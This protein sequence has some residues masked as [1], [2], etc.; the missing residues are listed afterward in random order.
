MIHT[1]LEKEIPVHLAKVK[2]VLYTDF[3][4]RTDEIIAAACTDG[5]LSRR[6]ED[7][8]VRAQTF[9]D[10]IE[11]Y[12]IA[13]LDEAVQ[14]ITEIFREYSI[15][16]RLYDVHKCLH[17]FQRITLL[18]NLKGKEYYC[19]VQFDSSNDDPLDS[20]YRVG[21]LDGCGE[22]IDGDILTNQIRF[23]DEGEL[24]FWFTDG[25]STDS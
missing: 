15:E 19:D 16:S 3:E 20:F 14:N 9:F 18:W 10:A 22:L 11:K 8:I 17:G 13:K 25:L 4:E 24:P 5:Y 12:Y 21:V 23:F 1:T 6:F 7:P 2:L